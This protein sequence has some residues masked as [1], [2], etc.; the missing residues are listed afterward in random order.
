MKKLLTL[1]ISLFNPM[2]PT[3]N[4]IRTNG[5]IVKMS[6]MSFVFYTYKYS[7]C[8]KLF[9]YLTYKHPLNII[10][11]SVK[12]LPQQF[13][14]KLPLL[15]KKERRYFL[16]MWP[17]SGVVY[18][19]SRPGLAKSAIA[20]SIADKMGFQYL[21]LR[22]SMVDETDVGL[23]PKLKEF[24]GEDCLDHVVPKWAIKANS[25]PTIIHFEEMNR[26]S[27]SVRNAALQILLEREIGTEFKFNDDVLMIS[28]GNLGEEDGCDV[29]EFDAAL[30]NRLIHFKHDMNAD[31][32]I[33]DYG[34][35]K[36]HPMI[37]SFLSAHPD[38]FYQT[39]ENTHSF[40]SPR[41]WTFLSDRIISIHGMDSNPSQFLEDI[42]DIATSYVGNTAHK[43]LQYCQDMMALS[44]RDIVDKWDKVKDD[45]S[46]YNR[47]KKSELI[48]GIK[49]IDIN[50]LS[51]KQL[52]NISA[53]LKTLGDDE[54]TSYLLHIV[55]ISDGDEENVIY[56]LKDFHD[57]L[58]STDTITSYNI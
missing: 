8:F 4:P 23:Y 46:K 3:M 26:A 36:C 13:L 53:F 1:L 27:L 38:R 28:S 22:L 55:D 42:Q 47:D 51:H 16:S 57:W 40:A 7:K 54:K 34:R 6:F 58:D 49:E 12:S 10:N 39:S 41:S 21:D 9:K 18:I 30:K 2:L 33:E 32:W 29:E 17:K 52:D 35:K 44:P 5:R 31:E 11:M 56:L 50:T 20:R 24:M 43:F 15:T 25:R 19:T 45:L 37:V 14:E 48:Q